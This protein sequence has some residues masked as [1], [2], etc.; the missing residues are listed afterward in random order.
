MPACMKTHRV[1][2]LCA[3]PLLSCGQPVSGSV[4]GAVHAV[5]Q[6]EA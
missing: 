1:E 3:I 5:L 4:H 6:F 2:P